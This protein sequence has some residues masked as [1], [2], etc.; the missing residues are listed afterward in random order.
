MANRRASYPFLKLH[1]DQLVAVN[2]CFAPETIVYTADGPKAIRDVAAGDLVLGNSGTYRE[3]TEKF[4]YDQHGPMVAV[5]IKHS[6]T[7]IRVTTGH[8]FFAIRGVPVEQACERTMRWLA[9]GKVRSQWVDAG[10][11]RPGDYVAQTIPTQI[12]PARAFPRRTRACTAFYWATGTFRRTAANGASP[13]IR[14]ATAIWSSSGS[15]SPRA[16]SIR[17]RPAGAR[18]ICRSIGRADAEPC[19]TAPPGASRGRGPRP[20]HSATTTCTTGTGTSASRAA[21]PIFNM[22]TP[23]P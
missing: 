14:S 17:G 20:C 22:G 5:K 13:A 18:P 8:P 7:P 16:A 15:I 11:L 1:N 2:Q 21:S 6:V 23:A 12:I 19:A 9:N 3:V 4:A 10:D